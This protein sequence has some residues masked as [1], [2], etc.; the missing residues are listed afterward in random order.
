MAQWF[1]ALSAFPEVLGL[2]PHTYVASYS[3]S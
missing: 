3:H 2:V 1:R